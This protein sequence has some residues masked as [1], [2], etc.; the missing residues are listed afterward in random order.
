MCVCWYEM[1]DKEMRKNPLQRRE[2]RTTKVEK[3]SFVGVAVVIGRR[4]GMK[5]NNKLQLSAHNRPYW[6][7]GELKAARV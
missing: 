4:G 3:V 6:C 2:E 5:G 7:Q 1:R